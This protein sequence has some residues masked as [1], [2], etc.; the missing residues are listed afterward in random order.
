MRDS[1]IILTVIEQLS[2]GEVS[3]VG[4]NVFAVYVSNRGNVCDALKGRIFAQGTNVLIQRQLF[5]ITGGG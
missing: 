4:A 5:E 3:G 1:K 2:R